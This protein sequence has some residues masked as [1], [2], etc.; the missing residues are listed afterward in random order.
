MQSGGP[1]VQ[2]YWVGSGGV[3]DVYLFAKYIFPTW[4]SISFFVYAY[5]ERIRARVSRAGRAR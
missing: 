2:F 1:Q 4:G 3:L 5:T